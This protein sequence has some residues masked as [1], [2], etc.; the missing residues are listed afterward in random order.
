VV[1]VL[2]SG[3]VVDVVSSADT[4]VSSSPEKMEMAKATATTAT[5][6]SRIPF[7]WRPRCERWAAM[8]CSSR[9]AMRPSSWR[10]RFSLGMADNLRGSPHGS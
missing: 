7:T 3:A 9:R 10:C 1:D 8:R 5:I 2:S 4:S 6:R